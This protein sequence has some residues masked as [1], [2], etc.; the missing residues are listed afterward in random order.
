MKS[1][2]PLLLLQVLLLPLQLLSP[3]LRART[4]HKQGGHFVDPTK[5]YGI[6]GNRLAQGS[7]FI[8]MTLVR[9][10]MIPQAAAV[11]C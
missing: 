7:K 3:S 1:R 9:A 10:S 5:P 8:I 4:A 6:S 11:A 2:L